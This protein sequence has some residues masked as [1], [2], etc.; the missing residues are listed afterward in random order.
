[1][2]S[3]SKKVEIVSSQPSLKKNVLLNYIYQIIVIIIPFVTTPHLSR[4]LL[5]EE[6]GAYIGI[7]SYTNSLVNFF[8]IFAALGTYTYGIRE[9]SKKRENK[10]EYSKLFFEIELLSV[11][12][13]FI[14]L[15]LWTILSSLYAEYRM[16]LFI[17][18]INILATCF[19]ISWF[20]IGLE[21]FK[22]TISVNAL[23]KI[24]SL[25][26]I[27]TLVKSPSDL[28][29][30]FFI[31]SGAL[32]LGNV[33]MWLFLPKVIQKEKIESA[34]MKLH[35]KNSLKYFIP[36]IA[37][38]IYTVLDKTLIGLLIPGFIS[39][40]STI[41]IAD[42]ES[43]FYEQAY[44]ILSTVKVLSFLAINNV[45]YSRV[46]N[47]YEK[48]EFG[49]IISYRDKTFHLTLNLSIG[50]MFGLIATASL[51]VPLYFGK[52]YD[53]TIILIMI[54][55]SLVPIICV[56]YTLGSIYYSPFGRRK[57]STNYL[58]TGALINLIF[59]IPFII[60]FKSIGAAIASIIAELVITFLYILK[61]NE[62]F[63]FKELFF[64]TWKKI[65]SGGMML[66]LVFLIRFLFDT[67]CDDSLLVRII[68][69]IVVV[70]VGIISY[71]FFLLLFKDK[72]IMIT[73]ELISKVLK[74]NKKNNITSN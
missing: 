73:K 57:Q 21:K 9:I 49:K 28:W 68:E 20:Y 31:S 34:N 24:I 70:F 25:V 45:M 12:T 48:K 58:I 42:V 27:L 2:K 64:I 36:S 65:I 17:L 1:M 37:T 66:G 32:L 44:K 19:D 11:I 50:A 29:I 5:V 3:E 61:S 47:L 35:F 67:Y 60:F 62:F 7:Y 43:G 30:Y 6:T 22:Y 4:V 59:N 74:R 14:S 52:G 15:A 41:R 51:F 56:S 69:L 39:P 8:I 71:E 63:S 53:K 46:C 55:S 16:Y 18:S 54:M 13:S 10:K 26:L 40:T 33:S 38:T 23:F 72:S